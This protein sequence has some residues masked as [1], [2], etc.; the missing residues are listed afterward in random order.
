M[1]VVVRW[2]WWWCWSADEEEQTCGQPLPY[3]RTWNAFPRR[4]VLQVRMWIRMV[5]VVVPP[6]MIPGLTCFER[7]TGSP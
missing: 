6:W 5:R 1:V 7:R 2:W 3:A 4:V